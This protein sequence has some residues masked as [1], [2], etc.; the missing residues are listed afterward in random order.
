[1]ILNLFREIYDTMLGCSGQLMKLL[2]VIC[3]GG[4]LLGIIYALYN[5]SVFEYWRF[6]S[7]RYPEEKDIMR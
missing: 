1:M 4:Y 3:I 7:N 6:L 2:E 5:I